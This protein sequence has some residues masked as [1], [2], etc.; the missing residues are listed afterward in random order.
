MKEN[1]SV[2]SLYG[3]DDLPL[4]L[5]KGALGHKDPP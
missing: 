5:P 1:Q 4:T 3:D 2:K